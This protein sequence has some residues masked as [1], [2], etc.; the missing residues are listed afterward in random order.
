MIKNIE[1]VYIPSVCV[2][3]FWM[4]V[5][6]YLFEVGVLRNLH[7]LHLLLLSLD[8]ERLL[9]VLRGAAVQ[10]HRDDLNKDK[11]VF[12]AKLIFL[13]FLLVRFSARFLY[14]KCS[15]VTLQI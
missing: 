13:I 3:S 10:R 1:C 4:Q 14:E 2:C 11:L 15:W 6:V 5:C 7:Q 8:H 9:D 12:R